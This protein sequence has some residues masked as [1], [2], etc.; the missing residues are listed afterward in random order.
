MD[1][2]HTILKLVTPNCWMVSLDLKD[3]YYSVEIHSDFQKYLKFTYHGLLYIYTVF[4]NGLSTCTLRFTNMMKRP[5]SHLRLLNHIISGYIND[6]YL[7]GDTY[8]RC[9]INV[10]YSI[11]M[12]DDL[13]L[14]IHPEMQK[15][16]FSYHNRKLLS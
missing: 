12:L 8:Q 11:K 4:P 5:L 9:I 14:V 6:F 1:T 2:I 10:I 7:Q 15:S 16:L 13:G 3:A